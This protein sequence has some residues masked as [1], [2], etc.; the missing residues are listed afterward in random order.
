MWQGL[1]FYAARRPN[2][3]LYNAQF[4]AML[5]LSPTDTQR[6]RT[7]RDI[8]DLSVKAGN[9]D[10]LSAEQVWREDSA[11][12]ARRQPA[13]TYIDLPSKQTIAESHEPTANGGWI[14]TYA[15]I[16]GRRQVEARIIHMARHDALTDLP[17]R[18]LFHEELE[19]ALKSASEKVAGRADVPR[20]GPVQGG[21]TVPHSRGMRSETGSWGWSPVGCSTRS[22][23]ATR[24]RGWEATS[25]RSSRSGSRT[26]ARLT[27]L[28]S[29]SS[30]RSAISTTSTAFPS[31]SKS[32]PWR[33]PLHLRTGWRRRSFCGTPIS[34]Y[35]RSQIC[36]TGRILLLRGGCAGAL[37]QRRAAWKCGP[38]PGA[39][40]RPAPQLAKTA[41]S[42]HIFAL[43][44]PPQPKVAPK[45]VPRQ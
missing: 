6:A 42:G 43:K 36:R 21:R 9:Y 4:C 27:N 40:M 11:F 34:R 26:K 23:R 12:I 17:N 16:T 25:S 22:A 13:L 20:S 35:A 44:R 2:T 45:T 38:T 15:D 8:V 5:G 10:G 37:K 14:R 1:A 32:Q 19:H 33:Q 41:Y 39:A 30:Q 31:A 29:G 3:V 7:H 24:L 18:V 28:P